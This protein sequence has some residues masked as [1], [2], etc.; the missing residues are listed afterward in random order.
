MRI[1]VD[2][3]AMPSMI[4]EILFRAAERTETPLVLVAN[5]PLKFPE[6][7]LISGIQVPAGPDEADHA[8]AGMVMTGDLVITADIPLAARVVEKGGKAV[9]PR[10]VLYSEDNIREK[11]AM[12][13]LMDALRSGGIESGGP[14][15]FNHRDRQ[16][17]ANQLDRLLARRPKDSGEKT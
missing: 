4:R 3:D 17:F 6:S 13:N 5:V 15:P 9:D 1:I 8:I 2:A 7:P 16:A 11:L 12:R 14:A 10:G